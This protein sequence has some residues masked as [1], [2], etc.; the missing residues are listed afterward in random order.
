M[1]LELDPIQ[2]QLTLQRFFLLRQHGVY[3]WYDMWYGIVCLVSY[4]RYVLSLCTYL[5]WHNKLE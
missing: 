5:V 1:H 2:S 4:G 3:V